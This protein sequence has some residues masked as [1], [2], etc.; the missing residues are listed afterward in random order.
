[1]FKQLV[2]HRIC[3]LL[4]FSGPLISL[5]ISPS[6]NYDPISLIKMVALSTVSFSL[7][8]MFSQIVSLSNFKEFRTIYI[9]I[10]LFVF[11]SLITFIFS[12]APLNQQIWG[13]FGR[14]TGLLTYFSFCIV[15]LLATVVSLPDFGIRLLK[16]LLLTAIPMTLYCLVQLSGN[17]PISWSSFD[18]FG[19][20]GNINFLSA[21]FGLSTITAFSI[22]LMPKIESKWKA[23][24]LILILIDIPITW[25][26]GS[27]QGIMMIVAGISIIILLKLSVAKSA[28]LK[29]STFSMLLVVGLVMTL[30]GLRNRG[31]L[32]ALL[33]QP[34]VTFREDYMHAGWE[35]T[36]MKPFIGVGIDSYGDWYRQARGEISTLRTGPDRTANTA[37]NIFLDISSGGGFPLGLVFVS[38]FL[39]CAYRSLKFA[40]SLKQFDPVFTGL[41]ST[42]VGYVVQ[43]LVSINQI[44]VGI[45]GFLLTGALLS[46]THMNSKQESL[47]SSDRKLSVKLKGKL[48]PPKI[49]LLAFLGAF[50]GFSAAFLPLRADI[51]FKKSGLG[52]LQDAIKSAEAMGAPIFYMELTLER[53]L[54]EQSA[55]ARDIA[56]SITAKQPRSYFAWLAIANLT[57]SSLSENEEANQRLKLLDPFNPRY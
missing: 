54:K 51:E 32:A 17:D 47:A 56:F 42:W 45:W 16:T 26:T 39:Y 48:L 2:M 36:L 25:S 33:F 9:L 50:L 37:H 43:A 38:I 3:Q 34:S 1:M 29:V 21:F 30:F 14:N 12:G 41:F 27:I 35:M 19:T 23:L 24:S 11:F 44:G 55:S 46:Y 22:L 49:A 18:T 6:A 8:L 40:L 31:P 4:L 53:A 5:I 10:A 28:L 7:L 15:L 13:Q 57:N 52:S 20:L